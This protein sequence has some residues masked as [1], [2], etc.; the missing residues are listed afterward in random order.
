MYV[1]N[2]NM[3]TKLF[4]KLIEL[5]GGRKKFIKNSNIKT[6]RISEY[7]KCKHEISLNK[8]LELCEKNNVNAKDLFS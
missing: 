5:S 3:Q 2:N 1:K 7:L 4:N 8:F 6:E